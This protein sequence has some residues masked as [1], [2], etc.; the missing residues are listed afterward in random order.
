MSGVE[1]A[2]L[3]QRKNLGVHRAVK[4][5]RVT[6]LKIGTSAAANQQAVA[7]KGH[8]FVIEHIGQASVGVAWSGAYL[9]R[10]SAELHLL[11]MREIAICPNCPASLRQGNLAVELLLQQPRAGDM[12]G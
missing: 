8:A 5:V 2:I 1:Q 6:M 11:A 7:G 12:V 3:R 10:P 4:R 9:K